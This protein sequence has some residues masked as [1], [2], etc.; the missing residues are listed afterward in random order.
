M[1]RF[2]NLHAWHRSGGYTLIEFFVVVLLA[3]VTLSL[4][5]PEF[6]EL[7]QDRRFSTLSRDIAS[8]INLARS[9]AIKR[10]DTVFITA[11]NGGNSANEFGP[12][13]RVWFDTVA[14]SVYVPDDDVEI[15]MF[16]ALNDA[17]TINVK[18]NVGGV[19]VDSFA[20]I[21]L[22]SRGNLLN[23]NSLLMTFCSGNSSGEKGR[24]ISALRSGQVRVETPDPS[25]C[26]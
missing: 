20:E 26:S 13:F 22:N 14:D 16:P 3:G 21:H 4:A 19:S 2:Y 23:A 1:Y 17:V 18:A 10:G 5:V 6:K 15:F 7:I 9:E 25:T 11:L 8:V 24:E 12:G